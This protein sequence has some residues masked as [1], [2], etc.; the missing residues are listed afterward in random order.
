MSNRSKTSIHHLIPRSAW[1]SNENVNKVVMKDT[2]H[3]NLHRYFCGDSPICQI[4]KLLTLNRK[5]F[6]DK[7]KHDL[8]AVLN[9]HAGD[10]YKQEAY[11]EDVKWDIWA[12][13][14]LNQTFNKD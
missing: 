7:F 5:V 12:V 14:E 8:L 6:T 11:I 2:E 9:K 3:V 1:G 4:V 10:Y 13:F